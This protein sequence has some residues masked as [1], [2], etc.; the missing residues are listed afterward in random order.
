MTLATKMNVKIGRSAFVA[1]TLLH[2]GDLNEAREINWTFALK[3]KEA[4]KKLEH[5][6]K[7]T[8]MLNFRSIG[9]Q[10]GEDRL[11]TWKLRLQMAQKKKIIDI[12]PQMK[13]K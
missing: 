10:I 6:K 9:C 4:M 7:L 11:N 5:E 2:E 3:G 13:K 12:E 1:R 8:G